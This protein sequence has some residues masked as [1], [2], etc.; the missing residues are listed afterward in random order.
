M[1]I[2]GITTSLWF[3]QVAQEAVDLYVSLFPDSRVLETTTY[4]ANDRYPEGTPVTIS[5]ELFGQSFLAI[6]AGPEFAPTPAISFQVFCDTQEEIDRLWDA[7]TE[8][9]REDMCGWCADRYGVSWQIIPKDL[10][11]LLSHPDAQAR[12]RVTAAMMGMRRLN[13]ADLKAAVN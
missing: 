3:D 12:G 9:G 1:A 5:F 7:L 8:G 2:T 10:P 4:G 6:N 13:I 11:G